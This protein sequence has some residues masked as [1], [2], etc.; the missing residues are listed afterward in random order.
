MSDLQSRLFR[1]LCT[2]YVRVID[3]CIFMDFSPSDLLNLFLPSIDEG[4][5]SFFI[6]PGSL[7]VTKHV[8]WDPQ[9]CLEVALDIF[10]SGIHSRLFA[11]QTTN[12]VRIRHL[13]YN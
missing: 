3:Y 9:S 13:P 10:R 6:P 1:N 4:G 11:R 2:A 5:H 8:F 7:F 12:W